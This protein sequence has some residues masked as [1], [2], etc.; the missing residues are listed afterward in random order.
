MI[1]CKFVSRSL[2]IK[3]FVIT[4]YLKLYFVVCSI[5]TCMYLY[6]LTVITKA[7]LFQTECVG[8]LIITHIS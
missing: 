3:Y 2:K 4:S 1:L 6:L 7:E 8:I 5:D